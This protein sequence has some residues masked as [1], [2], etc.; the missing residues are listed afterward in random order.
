MSKRILFVAVLAVACTV[1][2]FADYTTWTATPAA[3]PVPAGS[4]YA[5][6]TLKAVTKVSSTITALPYR[7]DV[8]LKHVSGETVYVNIGGATASTTSAYVTVPASSNMSM[9]IPANA[10]ISVVTASDP[11]VLSV[12]QTVA[13]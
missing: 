6:T 1:V 3:D 2:A 12:V 5:E 4:G 13:P 9:K 7:T 8:F 10:Y 11:A